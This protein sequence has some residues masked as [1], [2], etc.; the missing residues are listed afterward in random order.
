MTPTDKIIR[1]AD[2]VEMILDIEKKYSEK[3]SNFVFIV[4]IVMDGLIYLGLA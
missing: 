1:D 3:V 2:Y 4:T